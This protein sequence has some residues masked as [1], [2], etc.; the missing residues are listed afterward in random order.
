MSFASPR[1]AAS[2]ASAEASRSSMQQQQ[3]EALRLLEEHTEMF[4]SFTNLMISAQIFAFASF[5]IY[6]LQNPTA[7]PSTSPTKVR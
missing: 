4:A 6:L 2:D 1:L 3:E 7:S 5:V